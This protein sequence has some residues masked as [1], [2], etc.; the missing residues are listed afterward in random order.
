MISAFC[1]LDIQISRD[2]YVY[3]T[4]SEF[5]MLNLCVNYA[6]YDIMQRIDVKSA[7]FVNVHFINTLYYSYIAYRGVIP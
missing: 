5:T 2:P 7:L 4:K 3:G 6:K 1:C